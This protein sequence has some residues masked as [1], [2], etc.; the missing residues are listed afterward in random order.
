MKSLI[1]IIKL[2]F[3]QRTRNY[4]FLITLCACLAIA[5]TFVPEPNANYSTIRI[6]DYVGFYNSAWFGYVT[7]IMTSI[8]LSLIGFYLINSSIKNDLETKVG[9][10]IAATPI[11]N[12]S[13]LL[14]KVISNF[15]LLLTIVFIIFLMSI[16]LFFLYNDGYPFQVISVC[17]TI[18]NNN[19]SNNVFYRLLEQL[20]LKFYF[21]NIRF[22]KMYF[23]SF[24]FLF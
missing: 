6:S 16:I 19:N 21:R 5:Y 2:D 3:L 15:L 8:F 24:Y 22:Y 4:N 1:T 11:S 12:F 10:M 23:S 17:K 9:Q 14:S 18:L 20:F 13:Y 7:A